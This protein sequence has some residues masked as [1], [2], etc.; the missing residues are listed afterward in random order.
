MSRTVKSDAVRNRE[1]SH[2][3]TKTN[4]ELA[5]KSIETAIDWEASWPNKITNLASDLESIKNKIRTIL[6][7]V[8]PVEND[9]HVRVLPTAPVMETEDFDRA[10]RNVIVI[11]DD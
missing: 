8:E 9:G 10:E 5:L 3:N 6:R 4:L 7:S 2:A 1:E 11:G